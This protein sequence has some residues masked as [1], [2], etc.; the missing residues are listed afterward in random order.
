MSLIIDATK[1]VSQKATKWGQLTF[2]DQKILDRQSIEYSKK[3]QNVKV[4]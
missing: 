1:K 2:T 4:N 3:F